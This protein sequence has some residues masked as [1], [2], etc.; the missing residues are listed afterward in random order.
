MKKR[1]DH[2]WDK[3]IIVT[4]LG[5]AMK[6]RPGP[7]SHTAQ[8]NQEGLGCLF[9]SPRENPIFRQ[10][11]DQESRESSLILAGTV[12]LTSPLGVTGAL[13][14]AASSWCSD[15]PTSQA[16]NSKV[17]LT[18]LRHLRD[19]D[20]LLTGHEAQNGEDHEASHEAGGTVQKA[21]GDAVPVANNAGNGEGRTPG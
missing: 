15:L 18:R 19:G 2:S 9:P 12:G 11:G 16:P 8:H 7:A 3:G 6:A 1:Q 5:K 14:C 4:A 10:S 13:P 20:P 21:E 17:A